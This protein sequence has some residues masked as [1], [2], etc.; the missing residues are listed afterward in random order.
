VHFGETQPPA[1]AQPSLQGYSLAQWE[2]SGG[3]RGPAGQPRQGQLK[4][5]TTKMKPGYL[6]KIGVPYSGNAV[7]TEY[8]AQ[9]K[10]DDGAEY[11]AVTT[12]LD[13]PTYL[14]QPWVRTSQFRK[15]PD[16]KN[17]NPTPCSAQ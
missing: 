16:A 14:Q 5:T 12:M 4:V 3:G 17:W 13:D 7:L 10:D 1:A 8:F 2:T 6:R 9:L 15:Q 11:L